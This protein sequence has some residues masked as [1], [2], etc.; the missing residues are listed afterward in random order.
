MLPTAL[1]SDSVP[2]NSFFSTTLFLLCP[3]NYCYQCTLFFFLLERKYW[4]FWSEILKWCICFID[5]SEWLTFTELKA[6]EL[7]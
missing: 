4:H 2:N 3:P 5:D 7:C 6:A 1:K